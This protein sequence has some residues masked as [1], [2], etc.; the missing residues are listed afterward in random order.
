MRDF[1]LSLKVFFSFLMVNG[2]AANVYD[3]SGACYRLADFL[4]ASVPRPGTT[5]LTGAGQPS[6]LFQ[7]N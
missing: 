3:L 2:Q 1:F 7:I 6:L 5:S 4:I